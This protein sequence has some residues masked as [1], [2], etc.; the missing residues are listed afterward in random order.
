L[1]SDL[2]QQICPSPRRYQI[3]STLIITSQLQYF[4]LM[5]STN[6]VNEAGSQT[7]EVISKEKKDIEKNDTP[8]KDN[9]KA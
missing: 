6:P 5:S 2:R 7:P 9:G 1:I 8:A 4:C 3:L